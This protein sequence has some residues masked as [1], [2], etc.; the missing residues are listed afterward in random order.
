MNPAADFRFLES[1]ATPAKE[2]KVLFESWPATK[3]T[4]PD[5]EL[6]WESLNR[7]GKNTLLRWPKKPIAFLCD[8]HADKDAFLRSLDLGGLIRRQGKEWSLSEHGR[9]YRYVFGGDLFDKGPSTL[10]LLDAIASLR[11]Q[12]SDVSFVVGNHDIRT[13]LG[14]ISV[15]SEKPADKSWFVRMGKK[16][17][18]FLAEVW[19]RE[20]DHAEVDQID[21]NQARR[22]LFPTDAEMNAFIDEMGLWASPLRLEK[23]KKKLEKKRAQMPEVLAEHGLSMAQTLVAVKAAQRLFCEKPGRYS[24]VFREPEL[25]LESGSLLFMH[26]G[27]DDAVTTIV[28]T[29]GVAGLNQRF[30]SLVAEEDY[31][32]LYFG[33]VGNVFRT[34]Y[35]SHEPVFSDSAARAMRDRGHH[36]VVHG[37]ENRDNG[38][39]MKMR[40]GLLHLQCDASVDAG[41]R[42]NEGIPGLGGG[43]TLLH[44][45]GQVYGLSMDCPRVKWCDFSSFF[46]AIYGVFPGVV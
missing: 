16:A 9:A 36:I 35:R 43:L 22:I 27:L 40:S 38:Q 8:L 2:E 31:F 6:G 11:E 28:E 10:D 13:F 3:A 45:S 4:Q 41:T 5:G 39:G 7:Y 15:G 26:A 20:A 42:K 1:N 37:H 25:I 46:S 32:A 33:P 21:E 30:R 24:W 29:E 44:A 34:K 23:E 12:A 18:P 19:A 14:L 17:V